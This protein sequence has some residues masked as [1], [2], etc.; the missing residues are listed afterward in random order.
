MDS[1]EIK[2]PPT[3]SMRALWFSIIILLIL[4]LVGVAVGL[5]G[6]RG[7]K[8]SLALLTLSEFKNATQ[9]GFFNR[10]KIRM[11]R[12]LGPV[13]YRWRPVKRQ[14]DI[15]SSIF[16][17]P[18]GFDPIG[19]L[20]TL[21]DTN[22]LGTWIWILPEDELKKLRLENSAM[23]THLGQS[24][25]ITF[26][27]GQIRIQMSELIQTNPPLHVGLDVEF[28]PKV[29]AHKV[30]LLIKASRTERA[31][32]ETMGSLMQTNFVAACRAV[33]PNSSGIVILCRDAA[34]PDGSKFL[35]IITPRAID[36]Q[37]KP[38]KL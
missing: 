12:W 28:L 25:G 15:S 33:V 14:F 23:V 19:S 24:R 1:G 35:L 18:A 3:R 37:G 27:G 17:L 8:P 29:A 9:P 4:I 11:A 32:G 10:L 13:V 36:P 21:A 22:G 20:G 6:G 30:L 34:N 38:L 5:A 31:T 2:A 16:R 7:N 26:D